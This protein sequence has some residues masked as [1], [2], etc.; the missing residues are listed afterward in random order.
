MSSHSLD[1]KWG[2]RALTTRGDGMERMIQRCMANH[3]AL[4]GHVHW[5]VV[6]GRRRPKRVY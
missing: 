6:P 2:P 3:S 4:H 1:Y 5:L